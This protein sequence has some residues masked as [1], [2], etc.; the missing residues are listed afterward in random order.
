MTIDPYIIAGVCI[1]SSWILFMLL[2]AAF[3]GKINPLNKYAPPKTFENILPK[4]VKSLPT[5]YW[6]NITVNPGSIEI[7][8]FD[9]EA[10]PHYASGIYDADPRYTRIAGRVL[11]LSEWALEKP[12]TADIE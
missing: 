11:E 10:D 12:V 2:D 4:V 6:I 5:D 7:E 1:V 9:A 8:L 3:P